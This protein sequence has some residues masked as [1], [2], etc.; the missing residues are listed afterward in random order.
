MFQRSTPDPCPYYTPAGKDPK[1]HAENIVAYL[2]QYRV[3]LKEK[4]GD[5]LWFKRPW[6][7]PI[8]HGP[9]KP[10]SLDAHWQAKWV[11][12]HRH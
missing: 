10:H 8:P 12:N 7:K 9:R 5:G 3:L 6:G 1:K 11:E 4:Q 2:D